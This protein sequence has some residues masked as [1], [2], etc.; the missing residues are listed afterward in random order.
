MW[1]ENRAKVT[2]YLFFLLL[3]NYYFVQ[4]LQQM[5]TNDHSKMFQKKTAESGGKTLGIKIKNYSLK[6]LSYD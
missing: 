5:I 1:H 4:Q 6:H 3:T 2:C